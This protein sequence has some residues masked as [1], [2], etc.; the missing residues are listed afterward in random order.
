[1]AHGVPCISYDCLTGP[2]E[3][4]DD[5]KSGLLI[6]ANNK[7]ELTSKMDALLESEDLRQNISENAVDI[8]STLNPELIMT[9]WEDE[10]EKLL[11]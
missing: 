1:M 7:K 8:V 2:S 9:Q 11:R 10:I 3:I 6:E 5:G 4:I